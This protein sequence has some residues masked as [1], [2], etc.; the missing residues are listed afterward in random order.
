MATAKGTKQLNVGI[1]A[2]LLE[3]LQAFV[4]RRDETLRKAI[5]RA[6]RRDMDNPPPV[7]AP[8]PPPTYP[9]L[10]PVPSPVPTGEPAVSGKPK[11]EPEKPAPKKGKGK[12]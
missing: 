8:P 1:S 10:P 4:D 2:A 11:P 5:E 3:E 9:P 7:E 6:L 12:K